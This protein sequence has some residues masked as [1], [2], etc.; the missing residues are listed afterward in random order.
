MRGFN[1][2]AFINMWLWYGREPRPCRVKRGVKRGV[3]L[4]FSDK[5]R[6]TSCINR[7]MHRQISD[8]LYTLSPSHHLF[9]YSVDSLAN[10]SLIEWHCVR[11]RQDVGA[12]FC[13]TR[14]VLSLPYPHTPLEY[15]VNCQQSDTRVHILCASVF[16]S[17]CRRPK[18]LWASVSCF[19]CSLME[20]WRRKME[21][22]TF[23]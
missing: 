3:I 14:F 2:Y 7:S 16:Y 11:C 6:K 5:S 18:S 9:S 21:R 13:V 10:A 1:L 22:H 15:L 8:S 19:R 12:S 4:E 20:I 23:R 17:P